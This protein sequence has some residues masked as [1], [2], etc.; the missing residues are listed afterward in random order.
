MK[1]DYHNIK[2]LSNKD[3]QVQTDRSLRRKTIKRFDD[4]ARYNISDKNWWGYLPFDD[5]ES[6]I[7]SYNNTFEN[8]DK[9]TTNM[10]WTKDPY[11]ANVSGEN[12]KDQWLEYV[13]GIFPKN[14]SIRREIS[15]NK[16][17]I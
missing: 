5:K 12:W 10:W 13:I 4:F 3:R 16:I 7:F 1:Q 8:K 11:I 2:W 17:L 15:I 9:D 6:V 14:P